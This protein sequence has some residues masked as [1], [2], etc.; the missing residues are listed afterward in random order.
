MG[1][2]GACC[3]VQMVDVEVNV[4]MMQG[5]PH[6]P[7]RQ[8]ITNCKVQPMEHKTSSLPFP[9]PKDENV[10]GTRGKAWSQTKA[11]TP[12]PAPTNQAPTKHQ[13]APQKYQPH[14]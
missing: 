12:N 3:Q 13:S 6:V 1:T 5:I 2:F 7:G 14:D 10:F 11:P 9:H 8:N 4:K